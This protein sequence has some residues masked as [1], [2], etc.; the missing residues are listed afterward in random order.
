[1]KAILGEKNGKKVV[2]IY[3]HAAGS[4][5]ALSISGIGKY[6]GSS[7]GPANYNCRPNVD[8]VLFWMSLASL[9]QNELR[10]RKIV[11]GLKAA[12][13]RETDGYERYL[14]ELIPCHCGKMVERRVIDALGECCDCSEKR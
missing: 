2:A 3:G 8:D 4:L 7:L 11:A 5:P 14:E 13:T 10:A 9:P 1:M 6:H 12:D